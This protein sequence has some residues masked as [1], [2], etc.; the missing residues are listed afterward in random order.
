MIH[1]YLILPKGASQ[2]RYELSDGKEAL[3]DLTITNRRGSNAIIEI[4]ERTVT[5]GRSSGFKKHLHLDRDPGEIT[6][7]A[8]A[9]SRG[10]L[11]LEGKTFRWL[12]QNF[13]WSEWGWQDSND[14]KV[15]SIHLRH[16]LSGYQGEVRSELPLLSDS[17]K[18]MA[19]L[20]WYL[21]LLNQQDLG[22]H[23]LTALDLK[24]RANAVTKR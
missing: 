2:T 10:S 8:D 1:R 22:M 14:R 5:V 11:T 13:R 9:L 19:L 24:F 16:L 17:Q 23:I 6:F 7:M 18:E 21:L 3:A 20:G 12:P 15:I 4:G